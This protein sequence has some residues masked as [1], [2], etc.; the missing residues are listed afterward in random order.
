MNTKN[1]RF[2]KSDEFFEWNFLFDRKYLILYEN[3][4]FLVITRHGCSSSRHFR[5]LSCCWD[6][7]RRTSS[8]DEQWQQMTRKYIFSQNIIYFL[9]NSKILSWKTLQTS[10]NGFFKYF[11]RFS[12]FLVIFTKKAKFSKKCLISNVWWMFSFKFLYWIENILYFMNISV[13]LY[14]SS[15][16][17]L[18]ARLSVGI[19][20]A[21]VA[22]R[23]WREDEQQ[24]RAMTRNYIYVPYMMYYYHIYVIYII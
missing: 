21:Q 8:K 17:V 24:G 12:W 18:T 20:F 11:W 15:L 5:P 4:W 2:S 1:V 14:F 10:E 23:Q 6:T 9:S 16:L 7:T 13:F 22:C 3:T 19:F